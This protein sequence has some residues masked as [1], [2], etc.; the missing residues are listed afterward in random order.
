MNSS[1]KNFKP[2]GILILY[3]EGKAFEGKFLFKII[4]FE[5]YAVASWVVASC[6]VIIAICTE[7]GEGNIFKDEVA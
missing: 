4:N 6:F 5:S 2:V 1:L 7:V 3:W